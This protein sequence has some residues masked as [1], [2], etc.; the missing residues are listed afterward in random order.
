MVL[1]TLVKIIGVRTYV[2]LRAFLGVR[3]FSVTYL[4]NTLFHWG[5]ESLAALGESFWNNPRYPQRNTDFF[6]FGLFFPT[7]SMPNVL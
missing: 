7:A 2:T 3:A 1:L 6:A 5:R 4:L